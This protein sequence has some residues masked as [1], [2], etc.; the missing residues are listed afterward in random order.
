MPRLLCHA[1]SPSISRLLPP[2]LRVSTKP[3]RTKAVRQLAPIK[4]SERRELGR[5]RHATCRIGL[6]ASATSERVTE[7]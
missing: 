7:V 5:K 4:R 6:K 1:L 3:T 2:A